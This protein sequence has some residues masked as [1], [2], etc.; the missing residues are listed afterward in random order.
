MHWPV[1]Y[2]CYCMSVVAV[3][4]LIINNETFFVMNFDLVWSPFG[5][6]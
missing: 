3:E 2:F 4:L 5:D 6:D 1:L